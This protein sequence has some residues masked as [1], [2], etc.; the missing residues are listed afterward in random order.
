MVT[1]APVFTCSQ[2]PRNRACGVTMVNDRR[3]VFPTSQLAQR[4]RVT[5]TATVR[6]TPLPTVR[7]GHTFPRCSRTGIAASSSAWIG[8]RKDV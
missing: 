1:G 2:R 5:V 8:K 7:S 4:G 3:S 6:L